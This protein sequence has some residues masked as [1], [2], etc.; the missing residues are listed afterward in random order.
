[1]THAVEEG[2]TRWEDVDDALAEEGVR[3]GGGETGGGAEA[4]QEVEHEVVALA[5]R[6]LTHGSRS[7]AARSVTP[8]LPPRGE[9][10]ALVYTLDLELEP[11]AAGRSATARV[12]RRRCEK[13]A[14]KRFHARFGNDSF[15]YARVKLTQLQ[16]WGRAFLERRPAETP[17]PRFCPVCSRL[18]KE[19]CFA[20]QLLQESTARLVLS[21]KVRDCDCIRHRTDV[22]ASAFFGYR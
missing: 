18:M 14:Y 12:A 9:A 7:I 16:R 4:V 21:K 5:H 8:A 3:L 10:F 6:R 22:W 17:A 13:K 2:Y 19:D 15:L 1:M 20:T 11:T